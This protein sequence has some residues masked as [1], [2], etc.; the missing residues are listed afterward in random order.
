[1]KT[2]KLL[3]VV[4]LISAAGSLYAQTTQQVAPT[5]KYLVQ[6]PHI[7]EQCVNTLTE[8]KDKGDAF[9]AKFQFGCM[10]G[11]HTGY[12]FLDGKS[13]SDVRQ[14]LP[15]ELQASAKIEKVDMFT[16]AQIKKLHE[17]HM[18]TK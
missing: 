16:A 7:P 6:I 9:L 10:C 8:V 4:V 12:A 15:K 3:L 18:K 14:M 2:V 13:E 17:D 11:D 1:M 5:S